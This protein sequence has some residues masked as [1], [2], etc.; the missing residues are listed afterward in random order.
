[1]RWDAERGTGPVWSAVGDPRVTFLGGY[2]RK[3][4]LDDIPL[5]LNVLRGEMSLVGPRPERPEF[6]GMLAEMIPNYMERLLARPG[7]TGLA[8]VNLPPDTD[9]DSV[10]KKLALDLEYIGTASFW[11]D[12]RLLL[13]SLAQMT[14]IGGF[15]WLR[16]FVVRRDV[17]KYARCIS[18]VEENLSAFASAPANEI[19]VRVGDTV[20]TELADSLADTVGK[21]A[22]TLVATRCRAAAQLRDR[23]AQLDVVSDSAVFSVFT[24]EILD[25]LRSEISQLSLR[26]QKT[27]VRREAN[28]CEVFRQIR[29]TLLRDGWK[30]YRDSTV[31]DTIAAILNRMSS[32]DS[33]G[34]DDVYDS[35]KQ[36]VSLGL[37]PGVG[38]SAYGQASDGASSNEHMANAPAEA[39]KADRSAARD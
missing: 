10:A 35:M 20:D 12:V 3:F 37:N 31:R 11:M 26:D 15:F 19:A 8:Q 9:L 32:V 29:D 39:P 6:V 30:A 18:L 28:S 7:I 21:E 36:M 23:V 24:Q 34:S 2:L 5:L 16:F 14:G 17:T 4:H 22:G 38:F 33:V 13:C 25:Q 27:T 1:M